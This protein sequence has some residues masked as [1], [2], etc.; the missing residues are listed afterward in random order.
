[1]DDP[2]SL[3]LIDSTIVKAHPH[4][5][6]AA[7]CNGGQ[8]AEAL[9]RSRGGFTTKLHAVV[10]ERGSLLRYGL[11]GGE[12]HDVT[13]ASALIESVAG[14]A[15]VGDRAYDSDELIE[16]IERRGMRAVIPSRVNRRRPRQLDKEAYGRRNVIERFFGRLKV[17]RR[18]AI[19][20][21]KTACSYLGFVA[22]AAW[23]IA[24]SGWAR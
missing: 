22:S 8:A 6:G 24:M 15:V 17:F 7:R 16:R 2:G 21:D 20:Y 1:M 5:A 11:T 19:R 9:G 12:T 10:T 23:P 14:S 18:V 3:L 4:A 13:Q